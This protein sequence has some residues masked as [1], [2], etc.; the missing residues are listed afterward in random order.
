MLLTPAQFRAAIIDPTLKHLDLYSSAASSL[1]LGTALVE[2][3]LTYRRQIGGGPARGLFQ[4]EKPTFDDVYGRY[5]KRKPTL[6]ARVNELLLGKDPWSQVETNDRFACAIAR[7]RYLYDSK[8]LPDAGD[9]PALAETWLRVYNA[10]GKG[11]VA[12]FVTA[13]DRA[14]KN[15]SGS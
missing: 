2:S 13:W 15:D 8:P 1:L 11:T 3:D 4:I 14:M 12:K 6:L 9:I 7:V 10:G 5:L